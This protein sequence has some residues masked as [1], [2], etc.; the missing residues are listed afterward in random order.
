MLRT[1]R[2]SSNCTTMGEVNKLRQGDGK[3]Y[4]AVHLTASQGEAGSQGRKRARPMNRP[5]L[6]MIYRQQDLVMERV[7]THC[8]KG[9]VVVVEPGNVQMKSELERLVVKHGGKVE[10]NVRP[11]HTNLYIETGMTIKARNVVNQQVVDVVRSSWLLNNEVS[12]CVKDPQPHHLVWATA[13]TASHWGQKCDKWE[14][15]LVGDDHLT[16]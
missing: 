14:D 11:G 10:Q 8:L 4:G 15:N 6:G 16:I 7:D 9:K 2:D 12:D 5:G 13:D 3:L 1:D